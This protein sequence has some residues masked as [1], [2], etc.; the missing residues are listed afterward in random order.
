MQRQSIQL[1]TNPVVAALGGRTKLDRTRHQIPTRIRRSQLATLQP[2]SAPLQ[3]TGAARHALR[4]DTR[5]H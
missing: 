2:L 5:L 3:P 4:R 1:H